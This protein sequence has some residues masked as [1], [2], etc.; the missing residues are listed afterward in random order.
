LFWGGG[1]EIC[2]VIHV[3][4]I[5][6]HL[7]IRLYCTG[8][9]FLDDTLISNIFETILFRAIVEVKN[10]NTRLYKIVTVVFLK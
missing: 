2:F 10:G 5:C 9:I 4:S 6:I 7:V 8:S 1:G 3:L